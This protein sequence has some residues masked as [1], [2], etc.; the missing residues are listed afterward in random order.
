VPL[1]KHDSKEEEPFDDREL[2]QAQEVE[3]ASIE[4]VRA[5]QS[6]VERNRKNLAQQAANTRKIHG[7]Q[8][9]EVEPG[10]ELLMSLKNVK[11]EVP[12]YLKVG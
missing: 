8:S 3:R 6:I 9:N 5:V 7:L 11:C 1:L 2:M 12:A 10:E 4:D